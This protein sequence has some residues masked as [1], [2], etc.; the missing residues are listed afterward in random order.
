MIAQFDLVLQE[1]LRWIK[2]QELHEHYL[3][4][5]IQ[6][7]LIN[8]M[9]S[10]VKYSIINRIKQ[11]KYNSVTLDGTSDTNHK[12]EMALIVGFLNLSPA[13]IYVQV[14]FLEFLNVTSTAR[15][16]LTKDLLSKSDDIGLDIN[17][18][19]GQDYDNGS[20]TKGI[21]FGIQA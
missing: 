5:R 6:D 17:D 7:D 1:H 2:T 20:K 3:E 4:K 11:S 19:R 13:N 21:Y 18:P 10:K 16:E 8:L 14:H 15:E 12:E 9:A